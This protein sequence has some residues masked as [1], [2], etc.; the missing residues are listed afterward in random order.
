MHYTYLLEKK[1][2][3]FKIAFAVTNY[4]SGLNIMTTVHNIAAL[5]QLPPP[6]PPP[7][8]PA[9]QPMQQQPMGPI[10]PERPDC[11]LAPTIVPPVSSN[12]SVAYPSCMVGGNGHLEQDPLNYEPYIWSF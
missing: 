11:R 4:T 2:I 7:P 1:L 6:P 12:S 10:M 5:P 9:P 8:P 3:I